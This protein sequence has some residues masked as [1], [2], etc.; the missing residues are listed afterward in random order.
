ML[1]ST[2]LIIT[3]GYFNDNHIIPDD[4]AC[5]MAWLR[6][7]QNVLWNMHNADIIHVDETIY[8]SSR[9]FCN[10]Y[11]SQ[12]QQEATFQQQVCRQIKL[13]I[14]HRTNLKSQS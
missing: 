11:N 5:K 8:D 14:G 12:I 4:D 13:V 7:F 2:A 9:L 1:T 3:L 10:P 6:Y